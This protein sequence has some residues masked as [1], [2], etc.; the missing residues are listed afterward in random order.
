MTELVASANKY[1]A[2]S[3]LTSLLGFNPFAI[4]AAVYFTRAS[5]R[6][7]FG[8]VETSSS[9]LNRAKVLF[10]ICLGMGLVQLVSVLFFVISNSIG[11]RG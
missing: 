8:D 7:R 11:I 4:L 2:W 6:A 9:T 5:E 3:Y 1:I 10:W